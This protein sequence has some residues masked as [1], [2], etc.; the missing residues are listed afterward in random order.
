MTHISLPLL[1]AFAAA[2]AGIANAEQ[3]VACARADLPPL[4][5]FLDSTPVRTVAD[6]TRRQAEI[7]KLFCQYFIGSFPEEVP[8]IV[9]AEILEEHHKDDGSTRRRVKLTF[10]TPHRASFEVWVWI[11]DGPGPFPLLLTQPRFYQIYWAEDALQRGY[12][13]CLY[14]GLDVHHHE[15]DYP[16]Y[17]EVWRMFQSEYPQATWQSSLAIQA[18]WPAVR[19]TICSIRNSAIT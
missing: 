6:L 12:I 11:P 7:R 19:S 16:G 10:N 2:L 3:P 15:N 4:L 18:G 8:A 5:E 9:A 1:V 13:A 14:P 17:E